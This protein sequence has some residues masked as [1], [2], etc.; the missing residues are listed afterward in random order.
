MPG[1][2]AGMQQPMEPRP[3]AAPQDM[4]EGMEANASPEEQAMYEKI[5]SNAMKVIYPEGEGEG[6]V[7]PAVINT[8]K[9]SDNP[10]LS[11]ATAAV[12]IVQ[13]VR[14]SAQKAGEVDRWNTQAGQSDMLD[15]DGILYHVGSDIVADLAEV[16][17]TANIHDF[18]EEDTEQAFYIA[19]DMYREQGKQSGTL[20]EEQLKGG[21]NEVVEADKAGRLGEVLPGI[22]ERMG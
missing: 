18:N 3:M 16:A 5:V 19:L 20:D 12:A 15:F 22:E 21:W 2:G 9:S 11:A 17:E 1:L 8:L 10:V 4:S 13:Q 7:S 14:D 6:A